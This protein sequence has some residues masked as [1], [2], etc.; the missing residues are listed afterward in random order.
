MKLVKK[1]DWSPQKRRTYFRY[2]IFSQED[3]GQEG[4]VFQI[5]MFKREQEILKHHHKGMTEI[6]IIL[7]GHGAITINN[8]M[9]KCEKNDVLLI[10]KG[11][12][13]S[14]KNNGDQDFTIAICKFNFD[15]TFI[16]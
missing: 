9:M 7:S 16:W 1:A 4:C 15:D 3:I 5:V 10:E 2:K 14:I 6:Y 8:V 13:H 11:E 12:W